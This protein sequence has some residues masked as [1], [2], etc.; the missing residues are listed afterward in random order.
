MI[1]RPPRSTRTDTLVPYTTLCR[2]LDRL[3]GDEAHDDDAVARDAGIVREAEDRH[4]R[5]A[6]D[7]RDSLHI[8]AAQRAE[9]QLVAVCH[10]LARRPGGAERG[11]TRGAAQLVGLGAEP[12]QLRLPRA[13]RAAHL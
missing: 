4:L 9:D 12:S 11:V 5:G 7:R 2:S 3:T 1:R 6:R 8:L 13:R 10:H